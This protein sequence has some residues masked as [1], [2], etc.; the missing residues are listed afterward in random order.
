ML[1][2]DFWLGVGIKDVVKVI[3]FP[4]FFFFPSF[5]KFSVCVVVGRHTFQSCVCQQKCLVR[6]VVAV[7]TQ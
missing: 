5:W 2:I 1:M 3:C 7:E 6:G 4:F